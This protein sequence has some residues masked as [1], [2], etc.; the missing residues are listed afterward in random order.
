M[1][2]DVTE[3]EV[4]TLVF[5]RQRP[6]SF[7]FDEVHLRQMSKPPLPA[8]ANHFARNIDSEDLVEV[9]GERFEEPACSA[10]DLESTLVSRKNF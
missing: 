10:A 2:R 9:A 5:Q 6:E 8:S 3:A 7:V 4:K 1:K